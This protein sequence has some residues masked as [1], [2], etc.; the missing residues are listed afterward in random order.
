MYVVTELAPQLTKNLLWHYTGFDGLHGMLKNDVMYPSHIAYLNDA[1]EFMHTVNLAGSIIE[2]MWSHIPQYHR[3]SANDFLRR[4]MA[5]HAAFVSSFSTEADDPSQWRGYTHSTPSFAIGF[6]REGLESLGVQLV[7]CEY[8]L[9]VQES[10]IRPVV[11]KHSEDLE[12]TFKQVT[13]LGM[14]NERFYNQLLSRVGSELGPMSM[15]NKSPKFVDE[16]EERVIIRLGDSIRTGEVDYQ[17]ARSMIV[18]YAKWKIRAL[19]GTEKGPSPIKGI[20]VG[21]SPH[22]EQVVDAAFMMSQQYRIQAWV[23]KSEV[24]YRF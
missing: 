1:H 5:V 16:N 9:S 6:S 7:A 22:Q 21:P 18:P 20:I 2:R 13:D 24:P 10:E 23:A 8:Q 4:V 19:N 17:K 14:Q 15:R 12:V 11:E 3:A